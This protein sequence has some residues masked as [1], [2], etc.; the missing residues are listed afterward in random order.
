[1]FDFVQ[2]M[3]MDSDTGYNFHTVHLKRNLLGYNLQLPSFTNCLGKT[4]EV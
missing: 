4:E 1:M 3:K 2:I